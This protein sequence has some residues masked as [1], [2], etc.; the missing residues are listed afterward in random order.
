MSALSR[1]GRFMK[2]IRSI[3]ALCNWKISLLMAVS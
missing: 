2:P 3:K 1:C